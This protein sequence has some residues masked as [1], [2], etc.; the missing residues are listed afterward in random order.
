MCDTDGTHDT[1]DELSPTA[2]YGFDG[3][4]YVSEDADWSGLVQVRQLNDWSMEVRSLQPQDRLSRFI[5]ICFN[6]S[7]KHVPM[8]RTAGVRSYSRIPRNQKKN[9]EQRET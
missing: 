6:T 5:D 8:K 2:D 3:L 4:N 1:Q 9:Y 7:A